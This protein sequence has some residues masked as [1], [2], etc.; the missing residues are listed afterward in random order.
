MFIYLLYSKNCKKK[1]KYLYLVSI[2]RFTGSI[3][4]NYVPDFLNN[5]FFTLPIMAPD[6]N[7]FC[8]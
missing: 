2:G 5:N 3:I 6:I 8:Y 7:K 4:L 1:N